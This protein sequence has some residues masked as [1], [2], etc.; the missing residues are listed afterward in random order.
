MMFIRQHKEGI[1]V[2]KNYSFSELIAYLEVTSYKIVQH[3]IINNIIR[4]EM[5]AWADH[6][7]TNESGNAMVSEPHNVLS[8][9]HCSKT[10]RLLGPLYF[11]S[12]VL[13]EQDCIIRHSLVHPITCAPIRI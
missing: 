3:A 4:R 9:N 13:L 8:C 5:K 6:Y 10:N 12:F 11:R 2:L 1:V 7:T